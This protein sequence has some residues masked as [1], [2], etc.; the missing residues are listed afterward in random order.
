MWSSLRTTTLFCVKKVLNWTFTVRI[1]QA[2]WRGSTHTVPTFSPSVWP[3]HWEAHG[4]GSP[5]YPGATVPGPPPRFQNR[6]DSLPS[7]LGNYILSFP[8]GERALVPPLLWSLQYYDLT[9]KWITNEDENPNF[10][11][12]PMPIFITCIDDGFWSGCAPNCVERS[13]CIVQLKREV[14]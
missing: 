1:T 4:S 6:S 12:S 9:L 3:G 8:S 13:F 10:L 2:K 11:T 14:K 7:R 5:G